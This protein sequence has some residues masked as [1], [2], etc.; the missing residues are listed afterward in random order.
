MKQASARPA[1]RRVADEIR[2]KIK[3]GFF[4]G[5]SRLATEVELAGQSKV[6]RHTI[7]LALKQLV[8][9]GLIDQ[10]QGSGTY[11][12]GQPQVDGRYVRSIGSLDDLTMWPGTDMEVIEPFKTRIDA[13]VAA[14]LRLG[15]VEVD[16]AVVR[17]L[18]AG[19]AFVITRHHVDPAL[20]RQLRE[21]GIPSNGPGTVIGAAEKFL[22]DPVAGVQQM[23]TAFNA[24]E[25]I[26][27]PI[28]AAVGDAVILIERL[29]Y[30]TAGKFV[31]F[32]ESF[33]NPRR[34]TYRVD[35]HRRGRGG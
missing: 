16:T 19:E 1:Y 6:S 24:G 13:S 30:D 26:A 25:D 33:F 5:G 29:Y 4:V 15:Y 23:I 14:R 27:V 9:E 35:L 31:E 22:A 21:S 7:R 32:T 18:F 8:D 28:G 12:R 34:Y 3:S 2:Q 20:G 10:I 17:R 11:V